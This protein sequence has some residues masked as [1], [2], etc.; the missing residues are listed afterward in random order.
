M[1]IKN[2]RDIY[3]DIIKPEPPKNPVTPLNTELVT[4]V[5]DNLNKAPQIA[6]HIK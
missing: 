3:K 6:P 2:T 1:S 5:V 4:K